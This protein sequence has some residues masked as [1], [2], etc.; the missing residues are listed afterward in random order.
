MKHLPLAVAIA[1]FTIGAEP[2]FAKTIT[3]S[4]KQ[5]SEKI[6]RPESVAAMAY[7]LDLEK[8]TGALGCREPIRK[9]S[10]KSIS[11]DDSRFLSAVDL[12]KCKD[13]LNGEARTLFLFKLVQEDEAD[14]VVGVSIS[15]KC[16]T[17]E[18]SPPVTAVITDNS[19]EEVPSDAETVMCHILRQ[20]K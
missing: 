19:F 13:V 10:C 2:S 7:S 4:C 20:K 11:M 1:I 8:N 16:D 5:P 17:G 6:A 14:N 9:G 15:R 12:D 18:L 3:V